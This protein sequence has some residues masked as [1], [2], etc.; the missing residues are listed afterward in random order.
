[1][2][3]TPYTFQQVLSLNV[4]VKKHIYWFIRMFSEYFNSCSVQFSS[5]AQLCPTLCD[6][7]GCNMPGLPV[8]HQLL[9]FSIIDFFVLPHI[10]FYTFQNMILGSGCMGFTRHQRGPWTLQNPVLTRSLDITSAL[11]RLTYQYRLN[12]AM[13]NLRGVFTQ[14][15]SHYLPPSPS[16]F[17]PLCA[18]MCHVLP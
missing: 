5:V 14:P 2:L 6:P 18:E 17:H 13:E 8:Y 15:H 9:Y 10:L 1:M 4:L 7:M 3:I 11:K 16:P 12:V